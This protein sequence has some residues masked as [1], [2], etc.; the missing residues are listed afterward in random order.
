MIHYSTF[1]KLDLRG[2]TILSAKEFP[3]AKK[4]A[5]QLE[6]DFGPL[7]ILQSS[8]QITDRY[9]LEVLKGKQ[10]IAVVNIG[11]RKVA[12]FD[13]QCLV[14]GANEKDEVI[15]LAPETKLPN[16]QQIL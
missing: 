10:V 5:Y 6:I 13:S 1:E 15:L 12:D 2:G 11:T 9:A 16:G 8:A 3:K 7:G 14:L 4:P